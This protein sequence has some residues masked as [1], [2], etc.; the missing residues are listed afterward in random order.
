MNNDKFKYQSSQ[1]DNKWHLFKP[2]MHMYIRLG[3]VIILTALHPVLLYLMIP[4]FGETSNLIVF[5]AP[6]AAAL[7]FGWQVSL[8]FIAAN[9]I[10][11]GFMFRL[12]FDMQ[13]TEGAP[14]AL[15]SIVFMILF[16]VGADKLRRFVS[17]RR[18]LADEL[19][20]AKKMEAIGRLA[21]GVA[22]DMNNTLN[23][24]MGSVFA[25]RQELS[26][27]GR[28]FKDLDNIAAACDR[29]AQ[30]TQNLLGFARKSNFKKQMLSLNQVV[31]STVMLLQ[32]TANKNIHIKTI[33]HESNPL[34]KGDRSQIEN[35]VMNLCLNALDAMRDKGTLLLRTGIEKNQVYLQVTDTGDGMDIE[36]QEHVFEPF[37]TTKS[38][39]KGTGL[40][41]S[42]VYGAVHAMNG[43]IHLESMPGKGTEITLTFPSEKGKIPVRDLSSY[44]PGPLEEM[45]IFNGKTVLLIDDEPLVLRAGMRMLQAMGSKVFKAGSGQEGIDVFRKNQNEIS[46]VIVDLIMPDMDGISTLEK[47]H[48]IDEHMPVILVSGYTRGSSKL[49]ELKNRSH[50]VQFLAKPYHPEQLT[51]VAQT[52]LKKK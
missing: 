12:I 26:Q 18:T 45:P 52:L 23:A 11:T 2:D 5:I 21:G 22:H 29:G 51:A 30:L 20:Q 37:F 44:P 43:K 6:V 39:G 25:H 33:C 28:T 35:A 42:M 14:K 17:Q 27:Y 8:L 4:F 38:E 31:E 3:V 46:I 13:R 36:T 10:S 16:C 19:R 47:I 9:V 34:M 7:M 41:L 24:I 50:I 1:R 32:R 48:L 15:L 49:E 40:G